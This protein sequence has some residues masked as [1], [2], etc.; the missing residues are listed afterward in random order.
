MDSTETVSLLERY[1]I[2]LFDVQDPELSPS[3]DSFGMKAH[4]GELFSEELDDG[5][6]DRTFIQLYAQSELAK[7]PGD[8]DLGYTLDDVTYHCGIIVADV[9]SRTDPPSYFGEVIDVDE[10]IEEFTI[11]EDMSYQIR[12]AIAKMNQ[13]VIPSEAW[14]DKATSLYNDRYAGNESFIIPKVV[15]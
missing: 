11:S 8:V 1:L 2:D 12:M 15:C 13:M 4:M 5:S 14:I 9:V 6:I 7:K 10:F 3:P